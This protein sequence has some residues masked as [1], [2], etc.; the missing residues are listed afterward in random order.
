MINWYPVTGNNFSFYSYLAPFDERFTASGGNGIRS[1]K[2]GNIQQFYTNMSNIKR[3][4]I[5]AYFTFSDRYISPDRIVYDSK[6][7]SNPEQDSLFSKKYNYEVIMNKP[8]TLSR[9]YKF[10]QNELDLYFNFQSTFERRKH[11]CYIIKRIAE[12]DLLKQ[13]DKI[14]RSE[15]NKITKIKSFNY[16]AWKNIYYLISERAPLHIADETLFDKRET[17]SFE[18]YLDFS[19]I[20][21]MRESLNRYGLDITEEEREIEVV[22]LKPIE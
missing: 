19:D 21:K 16:V 9:F 7:K 1:D 6:E 10:M 4:Y 20:Q 5:L 12:S 22:V 2:Q 3:L 17:L 14:I 18:M 13:G 15:F 11:R 8:I